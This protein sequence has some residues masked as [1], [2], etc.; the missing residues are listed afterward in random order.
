MAEII[1]LPQESGGTPEQQLRQM[2]G[3]LYRMARDLNINFQQIGDSGLTDDE[4]ELMNQLTQAGMTEQ[5]KA[6]EKLYPGTHSYAEAET[7]KSLIIKTAQFVKDEVENMRLV[8]FGEEAAS[9]QFGDWTRKKGLRVDVTPDGVKQTYTYAELVQGLRTFEINSK[10]YIKTGFLRTE[11]MLPVYGVAIGKDV[12]TFAEDGTET[13]NDGNKVAELTADALS[14]FHNG[15]IL[16]KYTGTK[17]SFYAGGV[18]VMYI[19]AGKIYSN[20]DLELGSGKSV[21]IGDW[22]F[23]NKGLSYMNNN[24]P[25]IQF[26]RSQNMSANAVAGL[27]VREGNNNTAPRTSLMIKTAYGGQQ[28]VGIEQYSGSAAFCPS[29]KDRISLGHE[30]YR[31]LYGYIYTI[32]CHDVFYSGGLY[33]VSSREIKQDIRDMVD[34]GEKLDKLRPVTFVYTADEDN[35]QQAGLIYEE[36]IDL[37]PEICTGEMGDPPEQKAINYLKLVPYL[38]KE[39]Q[40]LRARVKALEDKEG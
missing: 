33:Q 39:I 37:M 15:V 17:T 29:E 32:M 13:Y 21:K 5:Q 26:G 40:T 9:G 2:F 24:T 10:N 20:V 38:L 31:W 3:Y 23:D 35:R 11:N 12:V 22:V 19:Q 4:Q 25:L 34:N 27:Y 6:E 16:A 1:E 14:F 28:N 30:D 7:L 18:E 36:V 8:L